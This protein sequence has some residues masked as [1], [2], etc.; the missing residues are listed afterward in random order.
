LEGEN[1]LKV[2]AIAGSPRP[3]GNSTYLLEQA[4]EVISSRGIETEKIILNQYMITPCHGHEDCHELKKCRTQD[5]VPW[6]L[7][8]LI[9]ADG[10]IF[11]SPVYFWSISAQIKTLLDRTFFLFTHDI[12]PEARCYG[13]IAVQGSEGAAKAIQEMKKFMG[14]P[15]GPSKKIFTLSGS[16]GGPGKHV[17]D[18]PEIVRKAR[19]LGKH[20]AD[21]LLAR[22]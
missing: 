21:F 13:F 22:D 16:A 5:D 3:E 20:M 10:L 12:Q 7:E 18:N 15:G 9:K 6:I 2:V 11:A 4:L 1:T 17:K 8:K 14:R 19:D